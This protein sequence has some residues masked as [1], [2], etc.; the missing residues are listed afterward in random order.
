MKLPAGRGQNACVWNKLAPA[1]KSMDRH[2]SVPV[3]E[4]RAVHGGQKA[5][6]MSDKHS[7]GK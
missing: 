2:M 6:R 5:R 7:L 1:S 4:E 3:N